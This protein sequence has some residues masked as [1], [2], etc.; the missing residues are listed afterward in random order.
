MDVLS[1]TN[2]A[3]NSLSFEEAL[4]VIKI[5]GIYI[6]GIVFYSVFVFKFYRFVAGRD[7]FELNL[8]QYNYSNNAGVKKFLNIILYILEYIIIFPLLVVF[9]FMVL[10]LLLVFLSRNQTAEG[11]LLTSMAI[12]AI[13]RV[14]SYYNKDL[15]KDLA[16]MLPFTL[17]GIFLIDASYFSFESSFSMITTIS[18]YWKNIIYYSVFV[19][20]LEFVLRIIYVLFRFNSD[21]EESDDE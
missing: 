8:R 13:V 18:V 2:N 21:N 16:K 15:S 10:F 7:I 19:I 5:L 4:S 12:I 3:I 17:L 6:V 1:A 11:V 20:L 14:T 9:W